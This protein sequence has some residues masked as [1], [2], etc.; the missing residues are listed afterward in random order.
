ME[1]PIVDGW[2]Q[3]AERLWRDARQL[4]HFKVGGAELFEPGNQTL[5]VRPAHADVPGT[6]LFPAFRIPRVYLL[7]AG[8]LQT[9]GIRRR[10]FSGHQAER[11]AAAQHLA[12]FERVAFRL[13]GSLFQSRSPYRGFVRVGQNAL[14]KR[15][16]TKKWHSGIC[17][18]LTNP[19]FENGTVTPETE[20]RWR[21]ESRLTTASN[22]NNKY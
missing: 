6:A 16:K 3:L 5:R 1:R 10:A 21:R 9:L 15:N 12:E 2:R 8:L 11:L 18:S 4:R 20:G 7:V 14:P 19:R 13:L 17:K 22:S